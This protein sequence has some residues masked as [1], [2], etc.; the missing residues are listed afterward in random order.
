MSFPPLVSS[1]PPPLDHNFRESDDDDEFGDFAAGALDGSSTTSESPQKLLTPLQTPVSS[2]APSPRVNGTTDYSPSPKPPTIDPKKDLDD[3]IIITVEKTNDTVSSIKL[4][5]RTSGSLKDND[6]D[7]TNIEPSDTYN[8]VSSPDKRSFDHI[9]DDKSSENDIDKKDIDLRLVTS[10]NSSSLADSCFKSDSSTNI[11][12]NDDVEPLSLVLDDPTTS[13]DHQDQP[14]YQGNPR[15]PDLE[16]DFYD[17]DKFNNSLECD[18]DSNNCLK[19]PADS[20]QD[21][22]QHLQD[23]RTQKRIP[24]PSEDIFGDITSEFSTYLINSHGNNEFV[25]HFTIS[26][27]DGDHE[28]VLEAPVHHPDDKS[29]DKFAQ[30]DVEFCG[31]ERVE[32][33]KSV[34]NNL[35]VQG[36]FQDDFCD[37]RGGEEGRGAGGET[38][39]EGEE[40]STK[41]LDLLG[42]L[43]TLE[44]SSGAG[45]DLE[46]FSR[47]RE[48]ESTCARIGEG[49]G[50]VSGTLG[51]EGKSG[52][53]GDE[54]SEW[55][56]QGDD[57]FGDFADF[58]SESVA[59][60]QSD[61]G[62]D[63]QGTGLVAGDDGGDGDDEFGDFGSC[64]A[65]VEENHVSFDLRESI[66]RIDN[67]NVANKIEDIILNM[68]PTVPEPRPVDVATLIA[69]EDVIWS[70]LKNIEETNALSYQWSNSASNNALLGAL[71][72]DSRNILFG[73]R[74]NPNIP[75]FAANLGYAPLE[76]MKASSAEGHPSITSS[77]SK[78]QNSTNLE[79]VPAAQFDWNSSGLVNPLDA[80]GGLSALLPLDLLYPF[81]PLLTT[82]HCSGHSESYHHHAAC[83]RSS[84]Y[85]YPGD[86]PIDSPAEAGPLK[87]PRQPQTSRIIEPLPGPSTIDWKKKP[88][89]S[90]LK[91]DPRISSQKL[92]KPQQKPLPVNSTPKVEPNKCD[93]K[94]GDRKGSLVKRDPEHTV[95]DRYGRQMVV[96]PETVQVLKQLPDLSF[97]SARTL[98][99]NP[100]Q[101]QIIQDLGAMINRKMPG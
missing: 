17:Y 22:D 71:G 88:K 14:D 54:F 48:G 67:K 51:R 29:N 82:P 33:V 75:R 93:I 12:A 53:D 38:V 85:Y 55:E 57:N 4:D 78:S 97:L 6:Y 81:D 87:H 34:N 9:L 24:E 47:F 5:N 80:S 64:P 42:G 41:K 69:G 18:Y 3:D 99:F 84:I 44:T 98:L 60:G 45:D 95:L 72:I 2:V 27:A 50:G 21:D 8:N 92:L 68:F 7:S 63:A 91:A 77:S 62:K 37:H 89:A 43:E 101:K 28:R 25:H 49:E 70:S 59:Q 16:D 23:H 11:E 90:E 83:T 40:I 86:S 74:W 30:F 39:V 15:P 76:P 96:K 19:N 79:E 65:P 66:C 26:E 100:E 35:S 1:T 46:S 52:G 61:W 73:P 20:P 13:G 31:S 56:F 10:S 58:S 32:I 94:S 36:E